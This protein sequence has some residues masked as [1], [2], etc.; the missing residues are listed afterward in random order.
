MS[1]TAQNIR[2]GLKK[3]KAVYESE[4]SESAFLNVVFTAAF[5]VLYQNDISDV[6][7]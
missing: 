6:N 5:V 3:R 1:R 4:S 7:V 2:Y